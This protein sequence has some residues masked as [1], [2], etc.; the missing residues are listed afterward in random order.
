MDLLRMAFD[1]N[2]H[3]VE[4]KQQVKRWIFFVE[5]Q[6]WVRVTKKAFWLVA[7]GTTE[8]YLM[9]YG[10]R[11]HLASVAKGVKYPVRANSWLNKRRRMKSYFRYRESLQIIAR[12]E[13]F[14]M[15]RKESWVKFFI[16]M[17]TSWSQ[18]KKD[19]MCFQ[20]HESTP[21]EDNLMKA[22]KDCLMIQDKQISDVR[23]SKFW[24]SG[25]G[26]IEVTLGELPPANGYTRII[27]PEKIK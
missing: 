14:V 11:K 15:P 24:Y 4:P 13:K 16:P 27:R 3:I 8:K 5:P 2:I 22:F 9:E 18:K 26:H 7:K 6:T 19:R 12:M 23:T 25:T 1:Q 21:D 10:M 20:L 17:P